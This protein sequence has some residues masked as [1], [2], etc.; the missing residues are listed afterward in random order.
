MEERTGLQREAEH[1]RQR[2]KAADEQ[3]KKYQ[4]AIASLEEKGTNSRTPEL[5]GEGLSDEIN[6]SRKDL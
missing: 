5:E 4:E 1:L 6:T 2:L 3:A